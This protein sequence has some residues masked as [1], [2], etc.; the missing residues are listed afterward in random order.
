MSAWKAATLLLVYGML[1]MMLTALKNEPPRVSIVN[2]GLVASEPVDWH[3]LVTVEPHEE[4][5][6][7]VV[8][9]DGNP[10][11]YRRSDFELDGEKAATIRQVWFRQLRQG[12]YTFSASVLDARRV[13]AVARAGPIHV[14]G[15]EGDPCG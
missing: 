7:L 5:R 10:G 1:W 8:E 13:L 14:L 11:E 6:L 3:I 9:V 2:R 12:C 15:R 4:H